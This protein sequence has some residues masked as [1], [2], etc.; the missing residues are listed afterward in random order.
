MKTTHYLRYWILLLPHIGL[1]IMMTF[2]VLISSNTYALSAT[3]KAAMG[4]L[5][6][7]PI[8]LMDE[9]LQGLTGPE[10]SCS[11]GAD[12]NTFTH[13]TD[14]PDANFK[15][16]VRPNVDTLYSSAMLDLSTGPQLLEM[17]AVE[18]R[19][20]LMALLDAWSNNFAGVGTQSHGEGE[21]RY[22]IVGPDWRGHTPHGYTRIKAPTNLV[23]IIGRT[24]VWGEED[25]PAVNNIQ[26]QYQLSPLLHGVH[27]HLNK[28]QFKYI[29]KNTENCVDDKNKTPPIDVVKGLNGEEFFTRLSSLIEQQPPVKDQQ[30][31]LKILGEIGVGP[32][33]TKSV[34][35]LSRFEKRQLNSGINIAQASIDAAITAMGLGGWGPNPDKIPLGDY[36]QRYLIRAIVAQVGFG[37][38]QGQYAVYQNNSRDD[39]HLRLDGENTYTFTI[40]GDD[41]PDVNAFGQ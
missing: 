26:H 16:V 40:K 8:V 31:M 2:T 37:A 21:G 29:G 41:L 36:N 9:T 39:Q 6:G 18:D 11:L 27:N 1:S 28:N 17:P 19:Y 35:D 32:Y 13:V 4:Y 15:A 10:R 14:I 34:N 22:V 23:W 30:W 25:I 38:N 3:G 33:A 7:F 20:V 12:I 24:E 5:Y